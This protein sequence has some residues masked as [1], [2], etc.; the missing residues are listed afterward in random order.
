MT[1]ERHHHNFQIKGSIKARKCRL[2][3]SVS[4]PEDKYKCGVFC[5]DSSN[6]LAITCRRITNGVK[7]IFYSLI[8][9]M[10]NQILLLGVY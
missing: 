10:T 6:L 7:T 4:E 5:F 2:G 8:I 9:G 3:N 1:S